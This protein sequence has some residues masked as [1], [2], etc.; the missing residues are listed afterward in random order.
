MPL[1]NRR[2][3]RD[4]ADGYVHDRRR[5]VRAETRARALL[6]E[7]AGEE[8]ARMYEELGFVAFERSTGEDAAYGY[9]V[10]PHR[11]LVSYDAAS[12]ELLSEYCVR[13]PDGAGDDPSAGRWLP[14]ADDVLAKWIALSA[15]E[16]T[17]IAEANMHLLGR[18]HDPAFVRRDIDR[19][20]AW[21]AA[22]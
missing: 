9:L 16:H 13:F 11:P 8:V 2:R 15:D 4:D 21:R 5:D 6:A 12:G 19:M 22:R 3:V 14:G 1:L 7:V 17:L 10:Y 20:R 18:Q